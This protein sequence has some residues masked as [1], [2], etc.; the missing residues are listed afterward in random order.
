ML[1]REPQKSY[2]R[3]GDVMKTICDKCKRR[4]NTLDKSR[5][6]PCKDFEK[7]EKK[8][9]DCYVEADYNTEKKI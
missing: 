9:G 2:R 7:K 5:G 3:F 4:C 8:K 1:D 6:M